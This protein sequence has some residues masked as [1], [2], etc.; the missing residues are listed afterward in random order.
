MKI[1]YGSPA[2]LVYIA[3]TLLIC[4]LL[5]ILLRRKSRKIQKYVILGIMLANVFQHIFKAFIYPQYT[6]HGFSALN[7]AYN[8]CAA[9]ILISPLVLLS[10]L[11]FLRDFVFYVGSVAG[12]IAILIPYWNIGNGAFDL[13]FVRS[14]IC[15]TLLFV[16]SLLPLLLGLHKPTYKCFYKIGICFIAT[17]ALIVLNDAVCVLLG[18][19][20]GVE[21]MPLR[22]A[23]YTV[24]PVWAF[25]PPES[26]SWVIAIAR[27][28]SP[29]VWVGENAAGIC[30][31]ILWYA[32]PMYVIITAV[33]LPVCALVDRKNFVSDFKKYTQKIKLQKN[34]I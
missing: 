5:F 29:D 13:E 17:V 19:Y 16:S 11:N 14:F 15:H 33:A 8:M 12:I 3:A 21:G 30:F 18:I 28:F 4:A 27:F 10:K 34:K 25:G 31:P 32:V 26:F 6:G 9:L 2:H 23:L 1:Y 20:P 22:E 24:N 7:T